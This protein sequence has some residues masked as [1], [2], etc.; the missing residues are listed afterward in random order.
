MHFNSISISCLIRKRWG[1][2]M[3]SFSSKFHFRKVNM[4]AKGGKVKKERKKRAG[5]TLFPH[6]FRPLCIW[7]ASCVTSFGS[8]QEWRKTFSACF[9]T[10]PCDVTQPW[11]HVFINMNK[12]KTTFWLPFICSCYSV[13]LIKSAQKPPQH[14][15][16]CQSTAPGCCCALLASSHC[17][18][19]LYHFIFFKYIIIMSPTLYYSRLH[20]GPSF[21]PLLPAHSFFI[22]PAC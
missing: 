20:K 19:G 11:R 15:N 2:E 9:I 22:R 21:F 4:F 8:V 18:W 12:K 5:Q 10:R 17:T 14:H 3:S 7:I 13:S 1:A 6:L 16:A